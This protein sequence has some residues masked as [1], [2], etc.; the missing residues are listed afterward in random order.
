MYTARLFLF[1]AQKF[2]YSCMFQNAKQMNGNFLKTGAL[3]CLLAV[4]FGAFGA[5]VLKS[6]LDPER[7]LSFETGVRYQFYHGLA[8]LICGILWRDFPSVYLQ[9]AGRLF[10]LGVV[11]F[12]G[13]IYL[14]ACRTPLGLEGWTWLGPITPLGGV[15]LI[16]GWFLLL[17]AFWRKAGG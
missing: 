2:D 4:I 7:L 12:S 3:F 1:V 8:L 13:S 6:I 5:H 15:L 14:L 17:V 16:A 9:N 10:T 11:F